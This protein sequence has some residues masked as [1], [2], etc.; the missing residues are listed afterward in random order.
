MG[1]FNKI[2]DVF[3]RKADTNKRSTVVKE[4]SALQSYCHAFAAN[5]YSIPEVRTAIERFG[6]IF[7][8]IPKYHERVDRLGNITYFENATS[9]VLNL[10]TNPL[11]NSMQFW[12]EAVTRL[13]LD[14]NVFI[15]PV[16]D[17]MTGELKNLYVVPKR[18]FEFE[19]IGYDKAQ[20]TFTD[21]NTRYDMNDIIYINRFNTLS[22]GKKNNLGLYETVVQALMEQAVNV[23]NPKKV[24]ALLTGKVGQSSNLKD[25]DKKGAMSS[26]KVNFDENVDG[27]AY[28]ESQWE[29]TPIKWQE[30]DV[31]RE[32]LKIVVN[33]VYN[34][35][36]MTENIVNGTCSEIE[37]SLFVANIVKPLAMQFEQEL[38]AKLF[39]KR[40]VEVGNRI[41][42]DTFALSVSTLS[43]KTS[44]FNVG[45]RQ[46]VLSPDEAREMI[47]LAPIEG[48]FGKMIRTTADTVDITK[49]N[50]YQGNTDTKEEEQDE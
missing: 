46:G 13:L 29:V 15:E 50:E 44:F 7:A 23:A 3:V 37:Y 10:N 12:N 18:P 8:T 30:N 5:I 1:I 33:T 24:R 20:V 39:T 2:K 11:Q 17:S 22:G 14:S 26:M 4:Y 42:F 45:L 47:G 35:F 21:T 49:V 6:Q 25:G 9:R 48:G 19:F 32:L 38:T 27:V 41:E 40:E 34:Y 43:A 16:F 31:N 36:G 28:M